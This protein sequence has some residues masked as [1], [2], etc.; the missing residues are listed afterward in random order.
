MSERHTV[1]VI[2]RIRSDFPT[3]FG[4]PRQ[5]GLVEE[6]RAAVVFE[7]EF[8]N[9]DALRGLEDFSHLW[10]IWQFSGAVR[11][12]WSPTVRP[13]RL[14]GNERMGVFATRSP[15][16][17]NPIGLSSVRLLAIQRWPDV[18]HVLLVAGAD[19]MDGT[20][21]YDIKPYVPYADSHPEAAGGFAPDRPAPR[22]AVDFPPA[23]L[24]RVPPDRRAALA[25]VLAQDPRPTYQN[26]PDRV[27]G[28]CF[29][30]LEIKFR[31]DGD[32]LTVRDVR[33]CIDNR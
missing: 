21:I 22:L 4:I 18:G 23:L 25:G 24:E 27:Y 26:S 5:S 9:K 31:V 14:G 7:P 20:P 11:E 30:G 33:S 12:R 1:Q 13:P 8:R 29:A 2:A 3:K 17:P 15:F 6:L 32:I 28:L 16:R 19:L 10:L